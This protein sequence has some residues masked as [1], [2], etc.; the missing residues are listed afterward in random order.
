VE[1]SFEFSWK[2][3]IE[4]DGSSTPTIKDSLAFAG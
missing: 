4:E 2:V 3:D 1:P